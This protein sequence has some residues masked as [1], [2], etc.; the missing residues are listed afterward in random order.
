VPE[1]AHD[2]DAAHLTDAEL[3]AVERAM[4]AVVSRDADRIRPMLDPSRHHTPEDFW[5]WAD[6]YGEQGSLT[7]VVPPG[8]PSSWE[9]WGVRMKDGG[10]ALDLDVWASTGRT[11]LTLSLTLHHDADGVPRVELDDLHVH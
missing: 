9:I 4:H 10:I 6:D 2:L 7:L 11:D 5:T 1:D 3:A 8:P